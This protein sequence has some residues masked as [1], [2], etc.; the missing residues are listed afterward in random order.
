[1][2]SFNIKMENP[3]VPPPEPEVRVDVVVIG[4]GPNGLIA[5]AYLARAGLKVV[6]LERR[7]EMGGGLATEEI[8][9]PGVYVNTH[10]VYHMM[11][12][13]MPA[14]RD[15]DLERHALTFIKPN[16][17]TAIQFSDGNSL[18]LCQNLQDTADQIASAC[19]KT[20]FLHGAGR[21]V[22]A[23]WLAF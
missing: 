4:G 23:L 1:M 8:L 16:L 3:L 18:I 22:T 21:A 20:L 9:Y 15:F 11:V 10:A 2:T 12:D 13:Y 6:L 14:I 5:A 17:Q 19:P 7:Q